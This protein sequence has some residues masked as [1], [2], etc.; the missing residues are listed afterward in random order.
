MEWKDRGVHILKATPMVVGEL[1]ESQ[2]NLQTVL[3][4]RHVATFRN[5]A[6]ELLGWLSETSDTLESWVKVQMMRCCV[7][8]SVF[9][10]GDTAKQLPKI[11]K[12]FA[13]VN[14]DWAKMAKHVC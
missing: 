9:K 6:Q 5:I 11:A 3:T 8:E 2:M 14:K 4:M 13:K 10:S 1:E 12:K 7:L